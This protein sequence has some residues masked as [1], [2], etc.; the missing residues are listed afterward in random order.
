MSEK[1]LI[2]VIIPTCNRTDLLGKCL[3]CLKGPGT[4]LL[5]DKCEVIVTDDGMHASA[6]SFLV[7]NYP[8][9][10]WLEGP[11]RGPAANRNNGARHAY[12]DWLVFVDDDCL[13]EASWLPTIVHTIQSKQYE[14][15]EGK[16]ISDE[17]EQDDPLK[18]Y[19]ENLSGGLYW[20]C[21]LAISTQAFKEL[22]GFDEDFLEAGGEDM[23]LAYRI[24]LR[25]VRAVFEPDAVVVHPARRSTWKSLIWRTWLTRWQLLY[26][27]KTGQGAPLSA[28]LPVAEVSLF[29]ELCIDL[30]RTTWHVFTRPSP[31]R[32]RKQIFDQFW[33]V[34]TFVIVV[35]YSLYWEAKFRSMLNRRS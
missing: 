22:G 30:L 7:R 10:R 28:P 29:I 32:R 14:V 6:E 21:N 17:G 25:K 8:W 11:H 19:I 31:L 5:S 4:G 35:P 27:L 9:V 16:T 15:I 23:E 2:S 3:D 24:G 18:Y 12:G 1:P 33:K 13:P 26:R 34:I 20:S